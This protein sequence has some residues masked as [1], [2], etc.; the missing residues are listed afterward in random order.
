[1]GGH[2]GTLA[3][4]IAVDP[5][6][7]AHKPKSLSMREA[8]VLPLIT[9]TAWEGL[10]DHAKVHAGQR[11]LIH[12]GAGGVGHIAVQLAKANGAEVFATVSQD[13]QH[14]VESFGAIP[15]D[16][17]ACSPEQYIE[18]FTGG[19]GFDI[20]YDT[21]GGATIDASFLAVKRYTGHVISCLGWSTH[22]LA[23]LSFRSATYSGVFT[24]S[25]LLNGIGRAN[26]GAIL[27][28]AAEL[29][30]AGKLRPLLNEQHFLASQSGDIEAA[31]ALV[32]AGA[33]GKVAVD[34]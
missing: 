13:K 12:A 30:D 29:A 2:Q 26:H 24:L 28:Q 18:K 32:A 20:V 4:Y 5:S 27:R 14:I 1:M 17:R 15:I 34:L 25:P 33:L 10:I 21:V 11:V 7:L 16:Y 3:E 22:S 6:L 23:P 19:E 9:I 31:H 8:A